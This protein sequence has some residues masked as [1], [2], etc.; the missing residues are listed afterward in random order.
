MLEVT[1]KYSASLNNLH[2]I[3]VLAGYSWQEERLKYDESVSGNQSSWPE[4]ANRIGMFARVQYNFDRRYYMSASCDAMEIQ[5]SARTIN[6]GFS[7]QPAWDGTSGMK[8]S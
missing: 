6:G 7:P 5:N 3:D 4:T 1:G 2:N 8:S